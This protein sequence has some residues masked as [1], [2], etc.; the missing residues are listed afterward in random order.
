MKKKITELK[1]ILERTQDDYVYTITYDDDKSFDYTNFEM[2]D[3]SIYERSDICV[4]DSISE[5]NMK[6][7][8][9]IEEIK[10]IR[11]KVD[12]EILFEQSNPTSI[13]ANKAEPADGGNG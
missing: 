1:E 3:E 4:A 13:E 6:V 10:Q 12:G 2:V 11:R 8:F 5:S 7:E 9:S